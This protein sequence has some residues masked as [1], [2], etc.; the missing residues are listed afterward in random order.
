[1]YKIIIKNLNLYGYHGVRDIEKADGQNFRFNIEI[2]LNKGGPINS[3]NL[4]DT[5]NYSE[6]IK[7]I[8][9]INKSQ[10]F[11]LLE[12]LSQKIAIRIFKMS[13]AVDK[14]SVKIEKTSPPIDEDIE[15]VGVEYVLDRRNVEN[16]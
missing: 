15:S 1:M 12:T 4:E 10:K 3:D 14:V 16:S 11:N 8:K 7:I 5:L 9:E 2:I 13:P 6:A